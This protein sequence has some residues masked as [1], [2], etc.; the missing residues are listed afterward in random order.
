MLLQCCR[1]LAHIMLLKMCLPSGKLLRRQCMKESLCFSR[2][3]AV[4]LF[5]AKNGNIK[6]RRKKQTVQEL[7]D[8][9]VIRYAQRF[10]EKKTAQGLNTS[11]GFTYLQTVAD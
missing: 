2:T 1:V 3:V 8:W 4:A 7:N 11:I 5:F 9:N 6:K 10:A